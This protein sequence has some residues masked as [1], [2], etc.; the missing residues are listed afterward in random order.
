MIRTLRI[1]AVVV[2]FVALPLVARAQTQER[3]GVP[4]SF[5][6][7]GQGQGQG[8]QQQKPAPS[9]DDQ[10]DKEFDAIYKYTKQHEGESCPVGGTF[11]GKK[12]VSPAK[13][14]GT[15]AKKD[16]TSLFQGSSADDG[17]GP[18]LDAFA[19]GDFSDC[20]SGFLGFFGGGVEADFP[21][22]GSNGVIPY[23]NIAA[24]LEHFGESAFA[25]QPSVGVQIPYNTI[26]IQIEFSFRQAFYNGDTE[27]SFGFG[28]GVA[29][30]LGK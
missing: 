9:N 24:G 5:D 29:V 21:P 28:A 13:N 8:K 3:Y 7:S 12:Q 25:Y 2:A 15:G 19:E 23:V 30:P 14:S 20:P 6:Q 11:R 22:M 26:R 17:A 27:S 16:A 10:Y 18:I 1:A 4:L